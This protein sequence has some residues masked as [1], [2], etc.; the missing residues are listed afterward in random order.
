MRERREGNRKG[1]PKQESRFGVTYMKMINTDCSLR[2]IQYSQGLKLPFLVYLPMAGK[3][4]KMY[5]PKYLFPIKHYSQPHI[6]KQFPIK[7]SIIFSYSLIVCLIA[8]AHTHKNTQKSV[9]QS[10]RLKVSS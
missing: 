7:S 6:G 3:L 4:K 5:Q 8:L 10:G 1:R 2:H 9:Y